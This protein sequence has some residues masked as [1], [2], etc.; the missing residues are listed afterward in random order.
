MNDLT[1]PII[2]FILV[3]VFM[4]IATAGERVACAPDYPR[5]DR[6]YKWA[7]REVDGRACWYQ[8]RHKP[9]HELYW[10]HPKN[11]PGEV[12][13]G[14]E[15]GNPFTLN[16]GAATTSEPSGERAPKPESDT[17]DGRWHWRDR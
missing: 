11:P 1:T 4:M 16:P 3:F 2:V 12:A 5:G 9:V 10:A 7:Y 8:G 15:E 17:F 14:I 13:P 6:E